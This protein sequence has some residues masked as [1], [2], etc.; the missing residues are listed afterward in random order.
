MYEV[1]EEEDFANELIMLGAEYDLDPE[2]AEDAGHLH[3]FK[4]DRLH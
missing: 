3:A 4:D 2:D 1:D